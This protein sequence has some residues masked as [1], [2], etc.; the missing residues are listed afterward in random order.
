MSI[1]TTRPFR[2]R[3]ASE[4]APKHSHPNRSFHTIFVNA[5][6]YV[7]EA[8]FEVDRTFLSVRDDVDGAVSDFY[9]SLDDIFR[10]HVPVKKSSSATYPQWFNKERLRILLRA[11]IK[12]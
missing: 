3:L 6:H 10:C 4:I 7:Y 9:S 12:S 2:S 1:D 8:L 5:M 11:N